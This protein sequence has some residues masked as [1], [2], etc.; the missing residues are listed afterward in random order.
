MGIAVGEKIKYLRGSRGMTQNELAEKLL[1]SRHLVSKW[2][3]GQRY[4]DY[5]TVKMIAQMFDADPD[6]LISGEEKVLDELGDCVPKGA[7]PSALASLITGFANSLSEYDKSVFL[8]RYVRFLDTKEI[9]ARLGKS[10]GTVRNRLVSL[11]RAL[12]RYLER[13][14]K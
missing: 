3:A 2:E 1:V 5:T 6:Y 4:P 8:M 14:L 11:R 7:D 10:D 13:C 12:R 9:A